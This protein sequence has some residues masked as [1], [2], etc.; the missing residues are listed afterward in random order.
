MVDCIVRLV[1]K[2]IKGVEMEKIPDFLIEMSK[3]M[4]E[5]DNRFTSD[6]IWQVRHKRYLVTEAGYNEHHWEIFDSEDGESA[7]YRSDIC[8]KQGLAEWLS[9]NERDWC[10]VW[11][12]EEIE[13]GE[14]FEQVFIEAF[15]DDFDVDR[16]YDGL[17]E[18]LSV[19]HLQEVEEV[20]KACLTEADANWFVNRKQHDYPKLYTYVE[21]MTFCPQMIELRNW[22]ISL[23]K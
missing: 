11:L 16:N 3:Q 12:D 19:L 21:S 9:E 14:D 22:I 2:V 18:R 23:T 17:P 1:F 5:Q 6:P 4:S 8:D 7:I 13:Y 15:I 10:A 20:V